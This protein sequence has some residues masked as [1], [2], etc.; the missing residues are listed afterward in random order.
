MMKNSNENNTITKSRILFLLS[1][2]ALSIVGIVFSVLC[3]QGTEIAFFKRNPDLFSWLSGAFIMV[4]FLISARVLFLEREAWTKGFLTLYIL[5]DFVLI[6]V[7]ILQKTG[8]FKV[9]ESEQAFQEWLEKAG[10]WMPIAFIIL[11]FLQVVILPIPT[12]V[13]T[14]V[15][16]AIF[17]AFPAMLY[18]FAGIL[19]A[20]IFAFYVGRKLGSKTVSWIVG[21]E[22]LKKW[23][24]KLKGKDNFF[25]SVMFLL[26]FF[27]DDV[28]CFIAGLST[29]SEKYFLV[30]ISITRLI[31]VSTTC[32]LVQ[33]IPPTTLWGLIIWAI[34]IAVV[35][36]V[37]W[38]VYKNM[39]KFENWIKKGK[40]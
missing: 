17:G 26:P 12:N 16:V 27:P 6:L 23:Q 21:E 9:I 28:L 34:L 18:S 40:N 35:G 24:S 3:I 32:Y 29:M 33:L 30:L 10:S 7:F 39:E 11:Q 2:F 14:L 1:F 15:G 31:T 22:T 4:F 5:L 38:L 8:F 37:A 25:L 19:P 13:S 20:S 36:L